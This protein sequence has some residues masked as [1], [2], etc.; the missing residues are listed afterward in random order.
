MPD[1]PL[2]TA[3]PSYVNSTGVPD[4]GTKVTAEL[5]DSI[6]AAVG[7]AIYDPSLSDDPPSIAR[8]IAEA[9]SSYL[10]LDAR[11]DAIE[12]AAAGG[13]AASASGGGQ[14]NL[15]PNDTFAIW[16]AGDSAAPDYWTAE[17]GLTVTRESTTSGATQTAYWGRNATK[18]VASAQKDFYLDLVSATDMAILNSPQFLK[19]RKVAG[20]IAIYTST[21]NLVEVH[22]DD[23]VTTI[24]AST[25][26]G[27]NYGVTGGWV[28][29]ASGHAGLGGRTFPSSPS[30]LRLLVRMTGAGTAWVACP[31]LY[32]AEQAP[33]YVPSVCRRGMWLFGND[34]SGQV[35]TGDKA[36]FNPHG[37]IHLAEARLRCSTA[38][39][40]AV[41]AEVY[42]DGNAIFGGA[43]TTGASADS[44][45][46]TPTSRALASLSASNLVRV[47][48]NAA[49]STARGAY[50]AVSW[51]EWPRRWSGGL[52]GA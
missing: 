47:A 9:R 20:G 45:V 6:R 35:P 13:A 52:I 26:V 2:E 24:G 7:G 39:A 28:W 44:G 37:P 3:W 40:T 49:D 31:A 43:I 19:S 42:K 21:Q 51:I 27:G 5:L 12:V 30:R 17:G 41:T 50:L 25:K 15:V 11:L 36:I 48:F 34:A 16:S 29:S 46:K 32:F 33:F 14:D 4:T 8:E 22:L 38:A 10:T 23:G 1:R 18:L